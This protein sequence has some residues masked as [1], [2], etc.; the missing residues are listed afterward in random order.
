MENQLQ[1]DRLQEL[2]Q[3]YLILKNQAQN[4]MKSGDLNNYLKKLL[5][6]QE[7]KTNANIS[8]QW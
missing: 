6:I 1:Q 5:E 4:L 7:V 3:H 2:K 8:I